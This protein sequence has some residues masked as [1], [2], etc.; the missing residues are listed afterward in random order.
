MEPWKCPHMFA[1]FAL[2]LCLCRLLIKNI[3]WNIF[4]TENVL[5]PCRQNKRQSERPHYYVS[6]CPHAD[7]E[8]D[9]VVPKNIL[10][11]SDIWIVLSNFY[12]TL[13]RVSLEFLEKSK[14]NHF[15]VQ[16]RRLSLRRHFWHHEIIDSSQFL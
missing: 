12:L 8:T 3:D 10:F 16:S 9:V 6:L 2:L 7:N 5:T 4:V 15:N 13:V 1:A 14:R 11:L